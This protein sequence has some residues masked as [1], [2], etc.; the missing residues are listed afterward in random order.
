[1]VG[2]LSAQVALLAFTAT[3]VAGVSV[4]NSSVTV[5]SR[6]LIALVVVMLLGQFV[7]WACRHALH[8]YLRQEKQR[9]DRSHL[10]GLKALDAEGQ[11]EAQS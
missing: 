3:L 6:A 8:E 2:T 1:M 7:A 4:G 5:L 9:I 10:D 11:P